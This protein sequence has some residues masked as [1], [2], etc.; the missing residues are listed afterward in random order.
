MHDGQVDIGADATAAGG[1]PIT[2]IATGA[3]SRV[4]APIRS[5]RWWGSLQVLLVVNLDVVRD[6]LQLLIKRFRA[7]RILLQDGAECVHEVGHAGL[8]VVEGVA[9]ML[10]VV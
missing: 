4:V 5:T 10:R 8:R 7:D 9:A 3:R 6:W 1:C 2:V